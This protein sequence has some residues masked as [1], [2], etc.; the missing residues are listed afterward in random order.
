M[1]LRS[2]SRILPLALTLMSLPALLAPASAAE[3]S[4]TNLGPV[5]PHEPILSTVGSK[6]IIAFYAPE[7]GK[8]TVTAVVFDDWASESPYSSARVRV[9]LSPGEMFHL[10]SIKDATI[11]LQ[12]GVNADTLAVVNRAKL[13]RA[14]AD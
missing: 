9:S 14:A 7:D 12:C 2:A 1:F 4:V 3:P 8:C 11:D 6:R 10:D 5:G 13:T